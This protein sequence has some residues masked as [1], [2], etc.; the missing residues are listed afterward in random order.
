MRLIDET[1]LAFPTQGFGPNPRRDFGVR[2]C[3]I[4]VLLG[5]GTGLELGAVQFFGCVDFTLSPGE[6]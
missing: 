6:L 1:G 2:I 4:S 3:L 5:L